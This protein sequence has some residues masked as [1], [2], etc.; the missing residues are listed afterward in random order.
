MLF[1]LTAVGFKVQ[2]NSRAHERFISAHKE[3]V[4]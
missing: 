4:K 2:N 1:A 3:R